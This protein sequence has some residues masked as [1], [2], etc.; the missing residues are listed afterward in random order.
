MAMGSPDGDLIVNADLP[1]MVA[2]CS[3]LMAKT[4]GTL[5]LVTE[6]SGRRRALK[7]RVCRYS[8]SRMK[9]FRGDAQPS[10][11]TWS[12][13]TSTSEAV[14]AGRVAASAILAGR[15]ASGTSNST[16]DL[17]AEGA[18]GAAMAVTGAVVD[19]R[20]YRTVGVTAAWSGRE[21]NDWCSGFDSDEE[22]A[23]ASGAVKATIVMMENE[24]M[25]RDSSEVM[26]KKE[27]NWR[28]QKK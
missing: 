2:F 16:S 18:A 22:D 11:R 26:T 14:T 23:T 25:D 28:L 5:M 24:L 12:H 15:S 19:R 1:S 10:D 27:I 8:S 4:I 3:S 13:S 6:P 21:V 7:W 20:A 9:P 17:V